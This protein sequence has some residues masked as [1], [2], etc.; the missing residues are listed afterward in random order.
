VRTVDA[1]INRVIRPVKGEDTGFG[2]CD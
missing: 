1:H 2:Y